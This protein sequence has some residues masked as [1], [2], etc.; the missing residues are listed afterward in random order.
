M[1]NITS[2]DDVKLQYLNFKATDDIVTQLLN[3]SEVTLQ[4]LTNIY[5]FSSNEEINKV[6]CSYAFVI[7]ITNK[8]DERVQLT[9]ENFNSLDSIF[10]LQYTLEFTGEAKSIGSDKLKTDI[11]SITE[12]FVRQEFL[13]YIQ[14]SNLPIPLLPLNF[15]KMTDD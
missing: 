4:I 15:W 14:K 8:S 13:N 1:Q 12:P 2:I 9:Q 11:L 7:L 10:K 3:S 5:N 6:R